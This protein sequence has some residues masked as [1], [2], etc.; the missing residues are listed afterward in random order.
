MFF[1]RT[2]RSGLFIV[3]TNRLGLFFVGTLGGGGGGQVC[4][5]LGDVGFLM[6]ERGYVGSF[7]NKGEGFRLC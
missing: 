7:W 5:V 2:W 1:V 6:E 4:S 3:G